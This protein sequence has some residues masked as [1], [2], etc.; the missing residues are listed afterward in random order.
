MERQAPYTD[1]SVNSYTAAQMQQIALQRMQQNA[2]MNNFPG[3]ID[4][5]VAEKELANLPLKAE[6]QGQ[7]DKNAPRASTPLS[8]H[9]YSEL[10][11]FWTT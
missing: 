11:F 10:N 6:G 4:S 5:F 1:H 2:G 9:P 8:S 3:R 7:W